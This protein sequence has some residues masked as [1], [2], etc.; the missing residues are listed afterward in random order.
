MIRNA[1]TALLVATLAVLASD[2]GVEAGLFHHHR[3][4]GTP[5][6]GPPRY[7]PHTHQRAGYPTEISCMAG[8]TNTPS[9]GGYWVGGGTAHGGC[10]RGPAVGTWGR[11]Y[12]G[13]FLPRNVFLGWSY[14]RRYQGG[15]GS[16]GS[17]YPIHIPDPIAGAT[18][19]IRGTGTFSSN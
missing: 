4:E 11:D 17:E 13:T 1:W 16:Y 2:R 12:T 15:T 18:S 14:G 3:E 7:F 9:Y 8:P 10:G 5:E 6:P 19:I